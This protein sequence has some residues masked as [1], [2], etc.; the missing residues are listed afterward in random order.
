[1]HPFLFLFFSLL[2]RGAL[3]AEFISSMVLLNYDY[4]Y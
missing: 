2:N 4:Y 1:M 3:K